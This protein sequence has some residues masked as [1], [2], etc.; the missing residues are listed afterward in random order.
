MRITILG[1][2]T[3]IPSPDCSPA[4]ILLQTGMTDALI[5][6]GP[7]AIYKAALAGIDYLKL[8]T[9][10]LTHLHS[11]HSLDLVTL[12][13]ASDSHPIDNRSASFKLIGPLGTKAWYDKLMEVFPGIA[14]SSYAFEITE[15][16]NSSWL[17][18]EFQ[19]STFLTGHTQT[20]LAYRFEGG[21][22]SF[23]Y[24]GDAVFSGALVD[25]CKNVDLLVCEC[26]FPKGWNTTDH[27]TADRVGVL[28]NRAAVKHLV[29]THRYPPALTVDLSSQI[30][31]SFSGPIAIAKDG[32][33]FSIHG[34]AV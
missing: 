27:M 9:V 20:S 13:Q 11:D 23:V 8:G 16:G 12:L 31:E 14:P 25:F 1:A 26:S 5:D 22:G 3:A 15:M 4:S 10:F 2:G 24:T 7:G 34:E 29:V 33:A 6:L 18:E 32:S 21:E 30:G 17:W 19:I 28:A